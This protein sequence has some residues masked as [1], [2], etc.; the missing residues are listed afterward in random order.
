LDATKEGGSVQSEQSLKD[1]ARGRIVE[2]LSQGR[3]RAEIGG[4]TVEVISLKGGPF[5]CGDMVEVVGEGPEG[6]IVDHSGRSTS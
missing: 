5:S 4:R 2:V 3:G 6:T 1:G